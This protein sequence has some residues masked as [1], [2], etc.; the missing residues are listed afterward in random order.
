VGYQVGR[1]R[2]PGR[3]RH[4]YALYLFGAAGAYLFAQAALRPL[5]VTG[6]ILLSLAGVAA[7]AAAIEHRPLRRG[8]HVLEAAAI[9][10]LFVFPG[11]GTVEK[12]FLDLYKGKSIQSTKVYV[13]EKGHTTVFQ[14]WGRYSL[15]EILRAPAGGDFAGFYNDFMQWEYSPAAGFNERKLGAVPIHFAPPGGKIAIIGAGG[16]RQVKWA[17]QPRYGFEKILALELEPAV[18]A[19]VRGPLREEFGRV[20]EDPRVVA[21][22]AEARGYMEAHPELYDLI[23]LPSV[24]GYP[25][26]MLEPGNMIRTADAYRLLRDRLTDRGILAIWYPTGLDLKGILTDQYVRTLG[27]QGLGMSTVAYWNDYE[28]LIL[29]AKSP[30]TRV[31]SAADID[32]FLTA[33]SDPSGLPPEHDE[34]ARAR[35]YFVEEEPGFKPI[36]DEQPFLAGNVRHILSLKQVAALFGSVASVLAVAGI[37]IALALRRSGDP[38]I[39]GRSYRQVAGLS[40]LIGANFILIEHHVILALFQKT[41]V[42][43]DALVLGAI[44]FLV[45]TGLGSAVAGG[46]SRGWIQ[47]TA[48]IALVLALVLQPVVPAIAVLALLAPVAFATGT[49]FPALFELAARNPLAVFALDAIG[50]AA[51]SMAAFFIPIAFGFKAY[52]PFAAAVFLATCLL[53]RAFTRGLVP[54][55]EPAREPGPGETL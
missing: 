14:E 2:F 46:R 3:M 11:M 12:A 40:F 6:L 18:F 30:A 13:G 23:F 26:M 20:Y 29:A 21:V 5:G 45:I 49:F 15:T 31:P 47:G 42:F 39:P 36:T 28:Y 1:A 48:I 35:P 52:F 33:P 50:A 9:G 43:H 34:F 24:G 55:P 22:N 44:S 38:R 7:A 10:A 8:L 25:Q 16:G 19:A 37:A 41:Y 27:S 54:E 51:G 4:V 17:L 53:T 32:A